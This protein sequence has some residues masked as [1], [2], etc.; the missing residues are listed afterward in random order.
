MMWMKTERENYQ[1]MQAE[2]DY[3]ERIGELVQK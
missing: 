2:L 3:K 1:A